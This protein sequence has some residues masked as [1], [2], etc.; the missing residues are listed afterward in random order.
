MSLKSPLFYLLEHHGPIFYLEFPTRCLLPLFTHTCTAGPNSIQ[1][2]YAKL[3][4]GPTV[5]HTLNK[6]V[7][8][9]II[10]EIAVM[11]ILFL[12]GLITWLMLIGVVMVLMRHIT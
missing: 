10:D 8:R 3:T 12:M 7:M 4:A 6:Y 5:L 11:L 2:V 9:E 1:L